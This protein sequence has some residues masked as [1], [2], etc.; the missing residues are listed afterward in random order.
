MLTNV[1]M[2][3]VCLL[4]CR[5]ALSVLNQ[6]AEMAMAVIIRISKALS[7]A[8]RALLEATRCRQGLLE[9]LAKRPCSTGSC[10]QLQ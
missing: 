5:L 8:D 10:L 2:L 4:L 9:A 3:D 1:S 7:V 6:S